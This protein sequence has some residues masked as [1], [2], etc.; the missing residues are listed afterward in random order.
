M[1]LGTLREMLVEMHQRLQ[2]LPQQ[3]ISMERHLMVP[4]IS[5]LQLLLVHLQVQA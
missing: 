2:N 4:P 1:L 5:P 3:K